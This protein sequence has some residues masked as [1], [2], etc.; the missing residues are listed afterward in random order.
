[1]KIVAVILLVLVFIFLAPMMDGADQYQYGVSKNIEDVIIFIF[2]MA[3]FG[4]VY[5]AFGV[6]F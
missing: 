6:L 3:V 5:W 1:M 4:L 2:A